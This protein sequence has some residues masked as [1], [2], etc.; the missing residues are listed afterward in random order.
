MSKPILDVMQNPD[1]AQRPVFFGAIST[2]VLRD[3]EGLFQVR[4]AIVHGFSAPTVDPRAV[5]FLA[6]TARQLLAESQPVKQT[7]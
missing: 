7:A 4:S 2:S 5:K 3:L 6:D 1:N